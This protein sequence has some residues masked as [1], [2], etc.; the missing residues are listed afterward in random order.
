MQDGDIDQVGT[1][2]ILPDKH[3]LGRFSGSVAQIESSFWIGAY[4][5]NPGERWQHFAQVGVDEEWDSRGFQGFKPFY[6]TTLDVSARGDPTSLKVHDFEVP[7]LFGLGEHV[8]VSIK[9]GNDGTWVVEIGQ[10]IKA[11]DF[12]NEEFFRD[13]MTIALED[14]GKKKV[15]R[16]IW[17]GAVYTCTK[18]YY[19]LADSKTLRIWRHAQIQINW[20]SPPRYIGI[21]P[22]YTLWRRKWFGYPPER[23]KFGD[24]GK[25]KRWG[26]VW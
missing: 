15:P 3:S 26:S 6:A 24:V 22:E 1:T 13:W 9:R 23:I 11:L 8:R 2:F 17:N 12:P 16:D 21:K 10:R 5:H 7:D 20:N 19:R 18:P 4:F 14:L 25:P